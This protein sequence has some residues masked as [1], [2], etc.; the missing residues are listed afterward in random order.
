[1]RRAAAEIID[2]LHIR[3]GDPTKVID[4][5]S[6]GNQQKVGLGKWLR[7]PL[8]LIVLDEPTQS[9]DIGAKADLMT[10]IGERA[11][12]SGLA[13]LWLES[14]VEELVR[15]ANRIIVMRAGSVVRE[16]PQRPFVTA[17]VLA[18]CY[19]GRTEASATA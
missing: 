13:V 9:I 1:V 18:A 7:L 2:L 15:Y 4:V 6:G 17:E 3:P 12:S 19:G 5:L 10:S 14:D 11:R 8:E 16:F